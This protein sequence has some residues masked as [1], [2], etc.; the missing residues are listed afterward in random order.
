MAKEINYNVFGFLNFISFEDTLNAILRG[1][2]VTFFPVLISPVQTV[3]DLYS[4][5]L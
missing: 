3:V 1:F 5:V 2:F 4:V